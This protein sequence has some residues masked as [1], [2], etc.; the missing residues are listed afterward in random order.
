MSTILSILL[1]EQ[2]QGAGWGNIIFIV[3]LV[4]IFYF[5]MIG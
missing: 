1:Q 3:A 4:A 2:A 5:F